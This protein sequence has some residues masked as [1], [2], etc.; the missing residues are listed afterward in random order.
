MANIVASF[1]KD[2]FILDSSNKP[3]IIITS[4]YEDD[5]LING[6]SLGTVKKNFNKRNANVNGYSFVVDVAY[7][8][9]I[10][11]ANNRYVLENAYDPKGNNYVEYNSTEYLL[12][13]EHDNSDPGVDSSLYIVKNLPPKYSYIK[14]VIYYDNFEPIEIHKTDDGNY[15]YHFHI[16]APKPIVVAV[17]H[18]ENGKRN[19][20]NYCSFMYNPGE[21]SEQVYDRV[22]KMISNETSYELLRVNPKLTGNIKVVVDS[23]SNIYL[24]TFKVSKGLSQRKYR[25]IKLNPD[26]YYGNSIMCSM[27]SLPSEDLYKIEDSCYSL[28]SLANN[29]N[30]QYYDKYNSGVRTNGDNMYS[31]N[32]AMLAPLC[33][34]K[35]MPDFFLIFKIKKYEDVLNPSDRLKYF[36]KNGTLVKSFDLRKDSNAGKLMR[37]VYENSKDFIGDLF[38]S[39]NYNIDNVYNGI[40][41]DR[42][43]VSK[44]HE[45]SSFE[46]NIKNQV[47]LNDWYTGGFERNR[48]VSKNIINFE[49]MFDDT[50][51]DMFSLN[52]YFGL[53]VKLNGEK[54]DFSCVGI[55]ED[56]DKN[57]I[58]VFNDNISGMKFNPS[59]KS[60]LDIIYG[61]STLNEFIRLRHNIAS[62][63]SYEYIKEYISQPYH[64]ISSPKLIDMDTDIYG[65]SFVTINVDTLLDVGEHYRIVNFQDKKIYEI[66]LSNFKNE[67]FDISG[68]NKYYQ[69]INESI[70]EINRVTIYGIEYRQRVLIES[71]DY[72]DNVRKN[73]IKLLSEA[74]NSFGDEIKSYSF[75]NH[76]S[77]IYDHTFKNGTLNT[78]IEKITSS[79]GISD[80][81]IEAQE[82][83]YD[84]STYFFNDQDADKIILRPEDTNENKK[85]L[86]PYEFDVLGQ[87]I[88]YCHSFI[89]FESD[90]S[91]LYM[92]DTNVELDFSKEKTVVYNT[93]FNEHEIYKQFKIY[94]LDPDLK[95][96]E[97]SMWCVPGFNSEKNYLIYLNKKPNVINDKIYFY[98]LYPINV[99]ICS[100][101]PIKDLY[102]DVLDKQNKMSESE[103]DYISLTGGEFTEKNNVFGTS[104]LS[105]DEEKIMNY[106]DKSEQVKIDSSFLKYMTS[107]NDINHKYSDLS[108]LFQSCCKWKSVGTDARGEYMRIMYPYKTDTKNNSYFIPDDKDGYI[109]AITVSDGS[110]VDILNTE[111]GDFDKFTGVFPKYINSNLDP[112]THHSFRDFLFKGNGNIDDLIHDKISG[113]TGI[114]TPAY[115]NGNDSLEFISGGVKMRIRSLNKSIFDVTKYNGYSS[116]LISCSGNNPYRLNP[117]EVLIDEINEQIAFIIYNGSAPFQMFYNDNNAKMTLDGVAKIPVIYPVFHKNSIKKCNIS[118]ALQYDSSSSFHKSFLFNDDSSMWGHDSS[119]QLV[120]NESN[121]GIGILLSPILDKNSFIKEDGGILYGKVDNN[122]S[123]NSIYENKF[124]ATFDPSLIFNDSSIDINYKTINSIFDKPKENIDLFIISNLPSYQSNPK[125]TIDSSKNDSDYATLPLNIIK[126]FINDTNITIKS[127]TGSKEYSKNGLFEISI[128]DPVSSIKEDSNFKKINEYNPTLV[129]TTYIEPVTKNILGFV[130]NDSILNKTFGKSFDGCN[131]RVNNINML[132]QIWLRKYVSDNSITSNPDIES[133]IH[134]YYKIEG[135]NVLKKDIATGTNI[136]CN[137]DPYAQYVVKNDASLIKSDVSF[138]V[139]LYSDDTS[140][141]LEHFTGNVIIDGSLYKIDS[142]IIS[143]NSD[144]SLYR[145]DSLIVSIDS[146]YPINKEVDI[147]SSILLVTADSSKMDVSL[148]Y[149]ESSFKYKL[150]GVLDV[151]LI[152]GSMLTNDSSYIFRLDESPESTFNVTFSNSKVVK[153]IKPDPKYT[154]TSFNIYHEMSPISDCWHTPI[155]RVFDNKG[156]YISYTGLSSGYEKN[157]FLASRGINLKTLKNDIVLDYIEINEW[158]NT[159]NDRFKK[160]I[161]LDITE[162]IINKIM[163]SDGYISNFNEQDIT[164]PSNKRKYIENSILPY[165]NINNNCLFELYIYSKDENGIEITNEKSSKKKYKKVEN[166]KNTLYTENNKYYMKIEDLDNYKYFAKMKIYL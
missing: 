93:G 34:K 30:E 108:I 62:K 19:A 40:S 29:L 74:F 137:D 104:I 146:P 70:Y 115:I 102:T 54:S 153:E 72:I 45:S 143:K 105:D 71:D 28:F 124:I 11:Y 56:K 42:G 26:E 135:N 112:R 81:E 117:C 140:V 80:S 161:I 84:H 60:N 100:I 44:I 98:N 123:F 87:R 165:I 7:L 35:N 73:E 25:K 103:E 109:G 92:I 101:F 50:E 121:D 120:A 131:I 147:Y 145:Y 127:N 149:S 125:T 23:S 61:M 77:V 17:G 5:V 8:N 68:I 65:K 158:K 9:N 132:D 12:N 154:L 41:I 69:N 159:T 16:D 13:S 142:S 141:D 95:M 139:E 91:K 46:R 163:Y 59:D 36:L 122:Y 38:V 136:L 133:I 14:D 47:A 110:D 58:P 67:E 106:F 114:L 3:E 134:N 78:V 66:I 157:M 164:D 160:T 48:I 4:G 155:Y 64:N 27:S 129:H 57:K 63:D 79:V 118:P 32:Y 138:V 18:K 39:Y 162:S 97:T 85:A 15:L 150:S 2:Y 130:Y 156:S 94:S 96:K 83:Y 113:S 75:D 126:S 49:F 116:I 43:V 37:K 31:E 10:D 22:H 76:I 55:I 90:G 20:K 119:V 6:V 33:I 21:T 152:D 99:G 107:L 53:Y 51:E 148:Y 111:Y 166:V 144:S 82:Y 151:S 52:T 24:D 89:P 88:A 128:V 86:Y 1:G